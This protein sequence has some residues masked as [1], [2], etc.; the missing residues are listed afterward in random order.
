MDV[1]FDMILKVIHSLYKLIAIFT[2][3]YDYHIDE[4]CY[5]YTLGLEGSMMLAKTANRWVNPVDDEGNIASI[6]DFRPREILRDRRRHRKAK[7]EDGY[8]KKIKN[9]A[10]DTIKSTLSEMK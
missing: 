8:F 9:V 5:G 10:K 1:A 3:S 4:Y 6:H 7:G 2:P